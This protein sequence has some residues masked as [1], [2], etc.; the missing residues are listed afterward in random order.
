MKKEKNLHQ[1]RNHKLINYLC[2]HKRIDLVSVDKKHVIAT[3]SNKCKPSDI[4]AII[5]VVCQLPILQKRDNQQYAIFQRYPEPIPDLKAEN[6][7]E[8]LD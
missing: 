5:A 8:H 3:L 1:L 6:E 2:D 4:K 7:E